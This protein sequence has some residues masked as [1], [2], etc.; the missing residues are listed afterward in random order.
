MLKIGLEKQKAPRKPGAFRRPLF[1]F[2]SI[3]IF[4]IKRLFGPMLYSSPIKVESL[5]GE[6][7]NA[8][9][10]RAVSSSKEFGVKQVYA[11]KVLKRKSDLNHFK[12]EFSTLSKVEG[13]HLV[14]LLGWEKYKGR[15][16][17][18][19]EFIDG[20]NLEELLSN[21][22]LTREESNWIYHEVIEGLLELNS[23][24]LYHGDL[25]PKNIMI[26]SKGEVKLIDFGLTRWRTQKIEVT[27]EFAAP[28]LL[29]GESP[30]FKH[31]LFSLNK[32]FK[33]LGLYKSEQRVQ[34]PPTSLI[35]KVSLQLS[36]QCR[37]EPLTIKRTSKSF[38]GMK[39]WTLLLVSFTFFKPVSAK[40]LNPKLSTV[41][42]RSSKWMSVKL[43]SDSDWCFTP[44]SLKLSHLGTHKIDWRSH[45]NSGKTQV[46]IDKDGQT[47]LLDIDNDH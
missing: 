43:P 24:N 16:G 20:V 2:F 8:N 9:V 12:K 40:N 31:D 47:L 30:N 3:D 14:R 34:N 29:G 38:L 17:L 21:N 4:R 39:S 26:S 18:L 32:I 36:P 42:I 46:F 7:L 28:E 22:S 5:L 13:K 10:Y 1:E 37:T 11:L 41:F 44:C 45:T 27:P 25:S 35:P 23:Q 6:G 33:Q 19:L 15:P